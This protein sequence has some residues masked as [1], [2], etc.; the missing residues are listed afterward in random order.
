MKI[1]ELCKQTGLSKD[2]VRHYEELG[3]IQ[4]ERKPAG[5]RYYQDYYDN[6]LGRVEMIRCGKSCGFTLKEIKH[7]FDCSGTEE[8][9]LEDI[10][11]YLLEKLEELEQKAKEIEKMKGIIRQNLKGITCE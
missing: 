11:P 7:I 6:S 5:T 2:G 10:R 8:L 1:S 3:L 9:A 4:S